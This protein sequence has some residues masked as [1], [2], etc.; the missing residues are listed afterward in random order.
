MFSF[1][2]LFECR[3]FRFSSKLFG[4]GW[5][6][7]GFE[8]KMWILVAKSTNSIKV[9][10]NSFFIAF[11]GYLNKINGNKVERNSFRRTGLTVYET[12]RYG[13][14]YQNERFPIGTTKWLLRWWQRA[15]TCEFFLS[16]SGNVIRVWKW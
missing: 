9:S 12:L 3:T 7:I 16:S 15:K 2:L 10:W 11:I 5:N 1:S 14:E 13:A 4:V 6:F 8:M